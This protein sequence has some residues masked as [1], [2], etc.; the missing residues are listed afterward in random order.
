MTTQLPYGQDFRNFCEMNKKKVDFNDMWIK[1]KKFHMLWMDPKTDSY[2][3]WINLL[4]RTGL[5]KSKCIKY[6]GSSYKVTLTKHSKQ[7]TMKIV[8]VSFNVFIIF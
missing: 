3:F 4:N 1:Q 5:K 7:W 6:T 2:W 8:I